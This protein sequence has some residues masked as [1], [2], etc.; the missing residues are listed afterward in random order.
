MSRPLGP[1]RHPRDLQSAAYVLAVPA[2][3]LWQ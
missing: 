2:L 1:L 3:A